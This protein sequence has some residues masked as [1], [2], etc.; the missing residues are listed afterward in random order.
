MGSNSMLVLPPVPARSRWKN[1]DRFTVDLTPS[2]FFPAPNGPLPTNLTIRPA[3]QRSP[4]SW[5]PVQFVSQ[6]P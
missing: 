6:A 2:C 1:L 5:E 3:G 4:R